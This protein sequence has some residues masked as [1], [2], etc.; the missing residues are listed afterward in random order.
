MSQHDYVIDNQSAPAARADINAALQAIATTNSGGT[1]PVTTYANMVWYDTATNQLKKRN[2]ADSAW[3]TMGTLDEVGGT[4]TPNSLLTTAG[5]A[6][7]TLVTSAE[8]IAAN[9]NNTTIPTSAA[10]AAYTGSSMSMVAPATA[11]DAWVMRWLNGGVAYTANNVT[12]YTDWT[13]PLLNPIRCNAVN[14]GTVRLRFTHQN[15]GSVSYAWVRVLVEG[16]VVAEW[17]ANGT[18]FVDRVVDFAIVPGYRIV[19]QVHKDP[20]YPTSGGSFIYNTRILSNNVT[21]GVA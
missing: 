15:P 16:T 5:I 6:P 20:S 7:A 2:E 10:V 19:V 9:N 13:D 11:G 12:A 3:I 18:F 17:A 21:I 4:F 8:G 14:Y 1:A